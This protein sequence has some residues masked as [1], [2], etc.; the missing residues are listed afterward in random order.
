MRWWGRNSARPHSRRSPG[1][2][3]WSIRPRERDRLI[4]V[5]TLTNRACFAL[6]LSLPPRVLFPPSYGYLVSSLHRR[7]DRAPDQLKR[8]A[9]TWFK[10]HTQR[11]PRVFLR[12][13]L[14]P[15][16]LRRALR[17][18]FLLMSSSL[19]S[20]SPAFPPLVHLHLFSLFSRFHYILYSSSLSL[21][22]FF[23]PF[24]SLCNSSGF[25]YISARAH[26]IARKNLLSGSPAQK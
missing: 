4:H 9:I 24:L 19:S 1:R 23:I 26:E 17:S 3:R 16:L 10:Q 22:F 12:L 7:V 21:F 15:L 25:G 8:S 20:S 6:P 13:P 11:P 18:L 14:L 2:L 5:A